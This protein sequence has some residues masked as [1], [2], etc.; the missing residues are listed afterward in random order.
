MLRNQRFCNNKP[1]QAH[2][3]T[4]VKKKLVQCFAEQ[5]GNGGIVKTAIA[6]D[7][8]LEETKPTVPTNAKGEVIIDK[9]TLAGYEFDI[10]HKEWTNKNKQCK[11]NKFKL[12][13]PFLGIALSQHN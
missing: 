10:E 9:I 7:E 12:Q 4:Q 2:N 11:E 13:Q 5:C 6:D 8:P 3:F 1:D